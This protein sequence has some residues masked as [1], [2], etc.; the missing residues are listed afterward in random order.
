[1]RSFSPF[2]L[3]MNLMNTSLIFHMSWLEHLAPI[4]TNVSSLVDKLDLLLLPRNAT[5]YGV[6]CCIFLTSGISFLVQIPFV[7]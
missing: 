7:F 6:F 5:E 4:D 3:M 2:F 1:M